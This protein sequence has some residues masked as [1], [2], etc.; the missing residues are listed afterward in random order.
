MCVWKDGGEGEEGEGGRRGRGETYHTPTN[1]ILT[2]IEKA[3]LNATLCFQPTSSQR[4]YILYA[5][6]TYHDKR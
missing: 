4:V 6:G 2:S 1:S 3:F 5:K